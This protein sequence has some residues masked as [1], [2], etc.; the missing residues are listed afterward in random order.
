MFYNSWIQLINETYLFLGT[1][2]AINLSYLNF[3]TYGNVINSL[4]ALSVIFVIFVFPVYLLCIYSP[5]KNYNKILE[6]DEEFLAKYGAALE[7]LNFKREGKNVF[8]YL[9]FGFAR[10]LI[11]I[12]IT[13]FM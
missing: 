1:C 6:S 12:Y 13:V 4:I 11:M 8:V 10:K 2:A 5:K 3:N 7:N 9:I